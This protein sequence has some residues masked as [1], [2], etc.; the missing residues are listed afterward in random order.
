MRKIVLIIIIFK[1]TLTEVFTAPDSTFNR[2]NLLYQNGLYEEAI[3]SYDSL[4]RLGLGSSALY[5]NLGNAYF[6]SNKLGKARLYYEKALKISPGDEDAAANLNY[7]QNL[8]VDRIDEVPRF[9]LSKWFNS[10]IRSLS[11]DRW[12]YLSML[13]FIF[14]LI[15]FSLYLFMRNQSLRKTGFYLSIL[16]FIFCSFSFLFS[17]KMHRLLKYPD[18]AIVIDLSV[19]VKSSP[20]ETGTGLFI[21]HEGAKVWLEDKTGGWQEI[22]LSDGRKGWVPETT[23]E[24]I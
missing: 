22:R 21:L 5:Y 16:F 24:S 7:L 19:N 18:S 12:A 3:E 15:L 20:R 13:T 1:L 11:S 10:V 9:F 2:A 23:L 8:L 14:S 6:R 17:W 4:I